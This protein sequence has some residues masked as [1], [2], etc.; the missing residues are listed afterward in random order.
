MSG[1]LSFLSIITRAF[2]YECLEAGGRQL[3]MNMLSLTVEMVLRVCSLV[4]VVQ[5]QYFSVWVLMSSLCYIIRECNWHYS[6]LRSALQNVWLIPELQE[7]EW[8]VSFKPV[9]QLFPLEVGWIFKFWFQEALGLV[10][11]WVPNYLFKSLK[12]WWWLAHLTMPI[13][14][15]VLLL[16]SMHMQVCIICNWSF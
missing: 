6:C 7:A 2:L 14:N 1:G 5:M 3:D 12:S 15:A 13:K 8:C 9:V 16:P 11:G 4:G 10:S